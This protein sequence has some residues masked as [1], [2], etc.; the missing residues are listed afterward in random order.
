MTHEP[1]LR[2]RLRH[3]LSC[4]GDAEAAASILLDTIPDEDEAAS[5]F[6]ESALRK[7]NSARQ[8]LLSA[9]VMF[10]MEVAK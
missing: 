5:M 1:T 4:L 9:P 3:A 2:V 8:S 7:L 6:V 10:G